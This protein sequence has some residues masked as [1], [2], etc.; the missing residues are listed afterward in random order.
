M[1]QLP[2]LVVLALVCVASPA[3]SQ[4]RTFYVAT[5]G[6]DGNAG[7]SGS[8]WRTLQ[9]AADVVQAGDLVIV[10]PGSY[11][12]FELETS[13]TQANPIE[14]RAEAGVVI[15]VA[16]PVRGDGINIEGASWIVIQGFTVNGMPHA[17]IRSVLN[18][19][20]TIRG[21][22]ANANGFWGVLTGFSDDVVIEDNTTSNSVNEHGIYVSNSAD[23]PIIRRNHSFGNNANGIHMN[24]DIFSDCDGCGI[25]VD[26]IISDALVEGNL[27]HDNGVFGGSGINCDGVQNSKIVNNLLYNNH[28]SGISLYQ[29]DG[30]GAATNN[31]VAH[32]TILQASNA[33]WALNIKDASTGNTVRN[34]ILYNAHQ[35][36]GVITLTADSLPGF[37]SDYNVVMDRFSADDG[38]TIV[39]LAEWRTNTG[40]DLHSIIAVPANLFVD[41]PANDYR[42]KSTS[43]ARNA[44]V[45]LAQVTTDRNGI[46][47]PAGPAVDIGAYEFPEWTDDP[48]IAAS[49]EVRAVHVL[50]LRAFINALRTARSMPAVS[51]TDPSITAGVTP[52]KA[53][54]LVELRTAL[55]AIYAHD[56]V[57]PPSWTPSLVAGVTVITAA[58]VE[59]IRQAVRDIE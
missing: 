27:I 59:Q 52:V 15:N 5:T 25:V 43:P 53:I 28:A 37:T 48:L 35:F 23:R 56:G 6:S 4:L 32:N 8:P 18:H 19:H 26:G 14:F 7:S 3:E 41:V 2:I 10:K 36:R 33:R 44:G 30:G 54:H 34:N 39:S 21:N 13:G 57:A 46:P 17:G 50:E 29:I 12:G 31:L 51:W 20:V 22:T 24:G 16:I 40:Q 1:R 38:D 45:T 11:A 9:H 47:R 42:L 58:Q 55:D 49:T